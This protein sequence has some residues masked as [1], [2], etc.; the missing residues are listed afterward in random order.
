MHF[1]L[2]S[3]AEYYLCFDGNKILLTYLLAAGAH[4]APQTPE[5]LEERE[6]KGRE[7][8]GM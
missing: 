2:F 4:S 1:F 7:E 6:E 3:I 5:L 8:E